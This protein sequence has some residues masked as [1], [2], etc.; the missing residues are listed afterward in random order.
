LR[1]QAGKTL[2]RA[3]KYR[4]PPRGLVHPLS[5]SEWRDEF[6]EKVNDGIRALKELSRAGFD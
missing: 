3:F 2:V 4:P 6:T 5:T 1:K